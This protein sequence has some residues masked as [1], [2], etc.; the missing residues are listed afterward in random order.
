MPNRLADYPMFCLR[1]SARV[2]V[3]VWYTVV[4]YLGAWGFWDFGFARLSLAALSQISYTFALCSFFFLGPMAACGIWQTVVEQA[5]LS[6]NSEKKNT[7]N[8]L[9]KGYT[10]LCRKSV[11]SALMLTLLFIMIH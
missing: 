4:R 6:A 5:A 9:G 2:L 8:L 1:F 10:V 7:L 3:F 11:Y